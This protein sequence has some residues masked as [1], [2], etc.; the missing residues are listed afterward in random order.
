[1][2]LCESGLG[3]DAWFFGVLVPV[4]VVVWPTCIIVINV[5]F[6]VRCA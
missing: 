2:G 6:G 1:M 3:L 4:V 5:F